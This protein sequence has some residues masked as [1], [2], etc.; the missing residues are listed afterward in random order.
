MLEIK[1]VDVFGGVMLGNVLSKL[2][3]LGKRK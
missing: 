2:N 1:G 3:I